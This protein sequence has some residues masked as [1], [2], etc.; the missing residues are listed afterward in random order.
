MALVAYPN[1]NYNQNIKINAEPRLDYNM[2]FT[3][4]GTYHI[5]MRALA[6]SNPGAGQ[7]DSINVGIDGPSPLRAIELASFSHSG[8]NP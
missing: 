5:W 8:R 2:N 7:N 4:A 1:I 3:I 6:D